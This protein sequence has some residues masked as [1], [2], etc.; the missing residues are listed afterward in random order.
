MTLQIIPDGIRTARALPRRGPSPLA[1]I[2]VTL[3]VLCAPAGTFAQT[4]QSRDTVRVI[5]LENFPPQFV[6][7]PDGPSGIAVEIVREVAKRADLDVEFVTVDS[8]SDVYAP[9]SNGEA[10]IL[11]SMGVTAQ[12]AEIVEFTEPY[13]VFDIKL[14]VRSETTDVNSV[15][16]LNGR[17]LGLQRTNVLTESLLNSGE[18]T[19]S[20]YP[21]FQEAF[22]GLL[23]GEVDAVV[24]PTE[25]FLR[26]ARSARLDDR[27]KFVGPSLREVKRAMAVPKGRIELRDRLDEALSEFK[28]TDDYQALI[29]KWYGAPTP[30]WTGSK[31]LILAGALLLST[32]L[33]MAAWRYVSLVK[34]NR[35]Y[36]V[37]ASRLA[38][39]IENTPLASISFDRNFHVTEWNRSAEQIFGF[40]AGE[41]QGRHVAGTIVPAQVKNEVDAVF[42]LLLANEGGTRSTNENITKDG[43][44]VVC[45]WYNTPLSDENGKVI[46]VSSLV[47]D[48][49]HRLE[50]EAQLSR[51][52]A[53]AERANKTKSEFLATMSHEFRTPLNAILGFSEIL[54]AQHFGPLGNQAYQEYA[55]DIHDSGQ[56]MLSLVNDM[57]DLA[58][59]EA[60][61]RPLQKQAVDIAKTLERCVEDMEHAAK[62]AGV[63]LSLSVN[64]ALPPL[65][66]DKRSLVQIVYNLL[67]N[68]I[69]YTDPGGRVD[70]SAFASDGGIAIK[71]AD[72]GIGIA[73]ER[74]STITEPFSQDHSEAHLS[75]QGT[76]L[77]L[78]IVKSLVDLHHGS[79]Q[80][81]STLGEGTVVT[82]TLPC[83][84]TEAKPAESSQADD[85][86]G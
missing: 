83:P 54:C 73:P 81:Q 53:A 6:P 56:H 32:V 9:L 84:P 31:I 62:K 18:Y 4:G 69:K 61:K 37:T 41:I 51:A 13:E 40:T 44:T 19:I 68:G 27:I 42:R 24:A 59:I 33:A 57:L 78:S 74:L 60:G 15:D 72:T 45:D 26:L 16:D 75:R 79:L 63:V 67:S 71:V 70:I 12:R 10:D 35:E 49:T 29:T 36:A 28:K 17:P 20:T 46:G 66:A 48:I 58:A 77:G 1:A 30:Y 50:T 38:H 82:V 21:S 52:L 76:G 23:S 3:L 11:S 85:T 5:I 39:H 25:P 7:T 43:R 80:L 86:V 55:R 47:Q 34:A 22:F 14:F 65:Q 8:W 2:F 64:D